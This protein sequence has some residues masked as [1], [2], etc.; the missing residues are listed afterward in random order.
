MSHPQAQST[1]LAQYAPMRC[2]CHVLLRSSFDAWARRSLS[3]RSCSLDQLRQAQL[4][5]GT[6]L[7]GGHP[8]ALTTGRPSS[9]SG[10]APTLDSGIGRASPSILEAS[11]CRSSP[12]PVALAAKVGLRDD[13]S[14]VWEGWIGNV[15]TW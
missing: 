13:A 6:G 14:N 10:V 9:R 7:E 1:Q 5:E 3:G 15:D 12:M 2:D 4:I 11:A 8:P